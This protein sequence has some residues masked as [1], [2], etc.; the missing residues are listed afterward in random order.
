[1]AGPPVDQA[2]RVVDRRLCGTA[3]EIARPLHA[4]AS[5]EGQQSSLA[6]GPVSARTTSRPGWLSKS[7]A[8]TDPG[9]PPLPIPRP[10][11]CQRMR[12]S[13]SG[14]SGARIQNTS[15]PPPATTISIAPVSSSAA[16]I[17]ALGKMASGVRAAREG[18]R[19]VSDQF[20][21]ATPG[22][23]HAQP[24]G[25]VPLADGVKCWLPRPDQPIR[26]GTTTI[27]V[28]RVTSG[29]RSGVPRPRTAR[30]L[31]YRFVRRGRRPASPVEGSIFAGGSKTGNQAGCSHHPPGG[32]GRPI[33]VV[34]RF[35]GYPKAGVFAS[36][37]TSDWP[38]STTRTSSMRRGRPTAPAVRVTKTSLDHSD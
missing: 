15:L 1:M 34:T 28:P 13:S 18:V 7:A 23:F 26:A 30:H 25:D 19:V 38:V 29:N 5:V 6:R 36:P 35:I 9:W 10:E 37:T 20:D 11:V 27:A 21:L 12:G 16:A 31:R 4:A 22:E 33:R 2:A 3:G 32:P 8:T 14:C 17:G 24:R